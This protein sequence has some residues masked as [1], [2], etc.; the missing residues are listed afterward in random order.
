MGGLPNAI[1]SCFYPARAGDSRLPV[2]RDVERLYDDSGTVRGLSA[3]S[4]LDS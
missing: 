4:W 2:F 1:C 3:D